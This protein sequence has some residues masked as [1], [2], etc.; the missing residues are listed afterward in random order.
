LARAFPEQAH[1]VLHGSE[2]FVSAGDG[3]SLPFVGDPAAATGRRGGLSATLPKRGEEPIRFHL[4]GGFEFRVSEVGVLG[5]GSLEEGAVAYSRQDGTSFWTATQEGYEEWLHLRAGVATGRAP[6]AEWEIDGAQLREASGA[7]EVADGAGAVQLRVTAPAAFAQGGRQVEARLAVRGTKIELWVDAGGEAVLVD[8]VWAPAATMSAA[9][10]EHTATL[11][12]SGKVLVAGG[13]GSAILAS[14]ELYDP[15][16]NTWSSAGSMSIARSSHRATLLSSGKVLVTGGFGSTYLASAELYD[17]GTNTWSSAGSM[18]AARSDHTATLLSSDKVLVAGGSGVGATSLASAQLYDSATNTWSPASSMSAA[19]SKHTATLF[20]GG[21][22]LVAGG[23]SAAALASAELYD[24][25]TNAWSPVSPMSAA[26]SSHTATLLSG[27]KVL[28]TGGEGAA[29][30]ASAQ[31]Y[32]LATNT[33][34]SAGSMSAARSGHTATLLSSGKVLVAGGVG[35]SFVYL[36]SAELYDP[37]TNAW[38]S[39]G[40]MSVARYLQTATLLNGK[41]LIVGGRSGTVGAASAELFDPSVNAWSSAGSMSVARSSHT[42]TVLSNNQVL[43][44]GGTSNGSYLTSVDLYDPPTNTW[45]AKAPITGGRAYHTATLLPNGS[46]L[47]AGGSNGASLTSV[48][49]YD[50]SSNS[51]TSLPAMS[52]AR[53][54]HTATLLPNGKVLVVGGSVSVATAQLFD[55]SNNTW[56][57]A[58]TLS[59]TRISHTATLLQNGNVLVTGGSTGGTSIAVVQLYT[60]ATNLWTTVHAMTTPRANHTATLFSTGSVLV[61]GGTSTASLATAELYNPSMDQWTGAGSMVTARSGQTAILLQNGLLLVAGGFDGASYLSS[62]DLYD[63]NAG[64]WTVV[65]SMSAARGFHTATLLNNNKVLM[66]GGKLNVLQDLATSELYT[67][68][69]VDDGNPCT[70]DSWSQSLSQVTHVAVAVGASCSDGNMCNGIDVCNGSGVCQSGTAVVCAASD[71]CHTAGVCAPATGICSNPSKANGSSCSDSNGCTQ[72]DTCQAGVCQ[73][74]AA[75]VCIASDQCHV[76]GVCAPATGICSNPVKSDGTSCNDTNACTQTD[77]C[78][79]GVCT[80]ASPVVCAASDQCHVAGVCAPATGICSNPAKSDGTSC[81][82]T[83]ACTQTDACQAGVCTGAS[84]VVCAASDQCH[85]VGVCASATGI[86][87]NPAKSDGT[88]CNDTNACTQTDACQAGVCTGASPVV[89]AAS[90]QCHVA[91][92]C[93]PA[94]GIC[95]NPAKSDGTS[96]NDTNACTQTDACQAGVCI[97]SNPIACVAQDQC[98]TAGSCNPSSGACIGG[99]ALVAVDDSNACTTD[100][101]N[102]ATGPVHVPLPVG[103]SCANNTVCDGLETCNANGVCQAGTALSLNDGDACTTDS[104][105]PISGVIHAGVDVDDEIVETIDWCNPGTGVITHTTCAPLDST[106]A[107]R[108]YEAAACIYSGA[109]PLQVGLTAAIDPITV[110]VLRGKV[111][112]RA[113]TALS[114]VKVSVLHHAA[115]DPQSLGWSFTRPDGA[116]ELV[117]NG[118]ATMTLQYEKTGYLPVQRQVDTVRQHYTAAP[119]VIMIPLDPQVTTV[120]LAAGGIAR[121]SVQ[122]DTSGQRQATLLFPAG[123]TGTITIPDPNG[124]PGSIITSVLPATVKFRATEY[125]VGANGLQSMP[126]ALPPTSAYTYAVELGLDEAVAAG[127]TTVNFSKKIPFYVDSFLGFPVGTPVPVGYFDRL[128]GIW[129]PSSDGLVIKIGPISAGAASV[130][131]DSTGVARAWGDTSLTSLEF[132]PSELQTLAT[133][134]PTGKTLWRSLVQHF[135]S[136]D[137]NF[138]AIPEPGACNPDEPGCGPGPGPPTPD[139]RRPLP[140]P[141]T[142]N[143]SI[144]ECENQVLGE[145]IPIAGTPFTLNYRSDRARGRTE[146]FHIDIPITGAAAPPSILKRIDVKVTLAGRTFATSIPCSPCVAGQTSPFDWD[147]NDF[148]G[149]QLSGAQ[150]VSIAVGYVYD[151]VYALPVSGGL[152]FG[153]PSSYPAYGVNGRIQS[154]LWQYW[155]D[156]LGTW[157]NTSDGLGGWSLSAH[158]T[159]DAT[160]RTLYRG[161]GTRRNVRSMIGELKLVF[162]GPGQTS[163]NPREAIAIGPD[164][165]IYFVEGSKVRKATPAGVTSLVAG[166]NN[167]GYGYNGDGQLATAAALS[168]PYGIAVAADSSVYIADSG[169]NRVRRVGPDG[170]ISTVAGNGLITY[171]P[172]GDGGAATATPV[173]NPTGVA[174]AADGTLY[175]AESQRVR[176]VATNGTI[177]TVAGNGPNNLSGDGG[178]A[179]LAGIGTPFGIASGPDGTIYISDLQNGRIRRIDPTGIISLFAGGGALGYS[180]DGGMA[181]AAGL[182]NPAGLAVGSDGSVYVTANGAGYFGGNR[183]VVRRISPDGKITT[184]IG[185]GIGGATTCAP[186]AC[187]GYGGSATSALLQM[188]R[189]VAIAKDASLVMLDRVC[190][191]ITRVQPAMPGVSGA[192]FGVVD[193]KAGNEL[194]VF[195]QLGRHQSTID[196]MHGFTRYQFSYDASSRLS[197]VTDFTTPDVLGEKSEILRDPVSGV[198]TITPRSPGGP[199]TQLALDPEGYLQAIMD[200]EGA[201][202]HL[203][204]HP[205]TGPLK[206]GA[207][208]L[209][210]LIDAELNEHLFDY[211]FTTGRLTKDTD[212]AGGYQELNRISGPGG[213]SVSIATRMSRTKNHQISSSPTGVET[214]VHTGMNGLTATVTVAK[215]GTRTVTQPDGTTETTTMIGDPRFGFQAPIIGTEILTIPAELPG[216]N[217]SGINS[218]KTRLTTRSRALSLSNPNDLLSLVSLTNTVKVNS[219]PAASTVFTKLTN[220][221]VTTT[222]ENRQMVTVFDAKGHVLQQQIS[223]FLTTNSSYYPD[224]QLY[225]TWKGAGA[226]GSLGSRTWTSTYDPSTG[227]LSDLTDPL[228]QNTHFLRDLVGRVTTETRPDSSF[229]DSS[230][231]G[232]GHVRTITPPGQSLHDFTYTPAELPY[233]YTPPD[234]GTGLL[235]VVSTHDFDHL[236]TKTTRMDS[237]QVIYSRD[238]ATGRTDSISLPANSIYPLL[239]MGF[240]ENFYSS[241]TGKLEK[242]DGPSDIKLELKHQGSL[243]IERKWSGAGYPTVADH[244]DY[245]NEL[246]LS[247][248]TINGANPVAFGYDDDGLL[249]SAANLMLSRNAQNGTLMGSTLGNVTDVIHYNGYGEIDDYSAD[250]LSLNHYSVAYTLRDE[251]GRIKHLDETLVGLTYSYDYDYDSVGR[252]TDVWKNSVNVGHYGYAANGNR[253]VYTSQAGTVS[254]IVYDAQDR[255]ITYGTTT[256]EY[257]DD[258][259]L[260]MKTEAGTPPQVTQYSYDGLGNLRQVILPNTTV[261][262][263][264]VDGEG[265]RIWKKVN[266]TVV[267]GF[268]YSD[269]LRIAAELDAAGNVVSRFIYGEKRNVPDAMVKNGATF[270]ILTDYRGSPRLVVNSLT[271]AIA[272][273]IDYD[274]FGSIDPANSNVGFQPFGF[275]GG[276]YDIHTKLVRFGARDYDA[277]SGRWTTK[278]PLRFDGGD[279]NLY[280][281]VGGDPIN[282]IDPQGR[283]A[284]F[285]PVVG[286]GAAALGAAVIVGSAAILAFG[287]HELIDVCIEGTPAN[288]TEDPHKKCYEKYLQQTA[289]CGSMWT[290]DYRYD[291]C[292]ENAWKNRI[293]CNN[294]LPPVILVP[295]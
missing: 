145:S 140:E 110:S 101:C 208:L 287:I 253:T 189:G 181:T 43:V 247:S 295:N 219:K 275:A 120:D 104:C 188:P 40:S 90:D 70:T 61:T 235:S 228:Q 281:Y 215:D 55:P 158:H 23:F 149:R 139:P 2:P 88:S 234:V 95:S 193:D 29:A 185:E 119:D 147:G 93:A 154:T 51:W 100:S 213:Y 156:E 62:A 121:G 6:A 254:P 173:T 252:L 205:T 197:G 239:A 222:P 162:G 165:T 233:K 81:N 8:P 28:M 210:S 17:P 102:P 4:L 30:L 276:L 18:S 79:A 89:C 260:A 56:G 288:D 250:Y 272:Q 236:L 118:G 83:N 176:R 221:L 175:I 211:D 248:E 116:F 261:I 187:C 12:S 224:G 218:A 9:R 164:D 232:N 292:M 78:Q 111:M 229:I 85:V 10:S 227:Y 114:G 5:E 183:G 143:G 243:L 148:F 112:T 64:I 178:P 137:C 286:L 163:I 91:G 71:Q 171:D 76:A 21:K 242:I 268:L 194:Y 35:P 266:G 282:K 251:L 66:S 220:T 225:Q 84:P 58:G 123:M 179:A 294:G 226:P 270:R 255:L 259:E 15:A 131:I 257:T 92:V 68:V 69:Q 166:L 3:F 72:S 130:V 46:V 198:I 117:V 33:W 279:V 97:G 134:Y 191:T 285:I 214:R 27:D 32:D 103:T 151:A 201:V 274:E 42:A 203:T 127:A 54:Q 161:D 98:H 200:P 25:G 182:A 136:Y 109:D 133:L 155:E 128:R 216:T 96:C 271:G 41:V 126:A 50:L 269:T 267:Q 74:G 14:A 129:V 192:S 34:S 49:L 37:G 245:N 159:Y 238:P 75:V 125:T 196:T 19:R 291:M 82:D 146:A 80:G 113:E 16:A 38:T 217:V 277:E 157:T 237:G 290:D 138:P 152:S 190:N 144:I 36:A 174:L 207:G 60:S 172:A 244:K 1:N 230:Y 212:P 63:P 186:G 256:Y 153:I 115:G 206:Q 132:T 67:P 241:S 31:L 293:R 47:V 262:D 59:G 167:N 249:T 284:I 202:T 280:A 65:P 180:G 52:S 20:S 273:R 177:S 44:V 124:P 209:K 195:D 231:D 86:C 108:L 48:M 135:T 106:V 263:Y 13:I 170:I 107:T 53:A 99:G 7:V 141:C 223:G 169:N 246:L 45:T 278:D 184:A 105:D 11:L 142:S 73:A 24:P 160:T 264:V 265:H 283:F 87:S 94:T 39:G 57:A 168:T 22:V 199:S 150:P 258:G 26:R 77:A 122:T 289:Y 240:L 204:Y